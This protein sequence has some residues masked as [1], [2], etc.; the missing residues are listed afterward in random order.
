MNSTNFK[1]VVS[2]QYLEN[3]GAFD[4]DGQGQCPQYWKY[5]WG[6]DYAIAQ[7]LTVDDILAIDNI[8]RLVEELCVAQQITYA[9]N[10]EEQYVIDVAFMEQDAPLESDLSMSQLREIDEQTTA[11]ALAE[12]S[13]DREAWDWYAL[14][15]KQ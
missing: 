8:D 9:S 7:N 5:K 12:A 14:E 13:A 4:W 3:Y 1:L 15:L 6:S 10:Y 2:T 11:A